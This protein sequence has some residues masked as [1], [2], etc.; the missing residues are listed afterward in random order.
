MSTELIKKLQEYPPFQEFQQ[1]IVT[2]I[3]KADT[4]EG[5]G[6]LSNERAGEEAKLRLML[7]DALH[8]IL[9]PFLTVTQKRVPTEKEMEKTKERFGL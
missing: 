7:K 8:K 5:V 3:E 1:L 4:V 9:D 2:I 6:N